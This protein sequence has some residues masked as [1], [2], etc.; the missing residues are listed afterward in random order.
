MI[1]DRLG[2][3][4][5]LAAFLSA[6]GCDQVT[7][8]FDAGVESA[9]ATTFDA[10]ANDVLADAAL[11]GDAPG[12]DALPGD[13]PADDAL[14]RADAHH[15]PF[16]SSTR[17]EG[18]AEGGCGDDPACIPCPPACPSGFSCFVGRCA[19][20]CS[21]GCYSNAPRCNDSGICVECLDDTDCPRADSPRCDTDVGACVECFSDMM[22]DAGRCNGGRCDRLAPGDF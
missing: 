5:P 21:R 1:A 8:T 13:A 22:C 14:T 2:W 6:V 19:V 17:P 11:P 15:E 16:D 10:F 20:T 12:D 18:L 7:W 9:D 4:A 3:A